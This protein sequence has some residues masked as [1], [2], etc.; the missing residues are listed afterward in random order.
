[1][2]KPN[3]EIDKIEKPSEVTKPP[4][5][6]GAIINPAVLLIKTLVTFK[7]PITLCKILYRVRRQ[8]MNCEGPTVMAI[9]PKNIWLLK[10]NRYH[11]LETISFFLN[12]PVCSET[13]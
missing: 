6:N 13:R 10:V 11:R 7:Y 8:V 3:H 5:A 12:M 1:M 2:V 9:R 4:I